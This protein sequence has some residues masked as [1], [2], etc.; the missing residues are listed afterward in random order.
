MTARKPLSKRSKYIVDTDIIK[1]EKKEKRSL[2][3]RPR[4]S[5]LGDREEVRSKKVILL[6]YG[7]VEL[8]I[9]TAKQR[10]YVCSNNGGPAPLTHELPPPPKRRRQVTY[11]EAVE[12]TLQPVRV[13][14]DGVFDIFHPG[15]ARALMQAKNA[16]PNVH[17][18]AGGIHINPFSSQY[19]IY[20]LCSDM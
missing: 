17:L 5:A 1:E 7:F 16:F 13:Y 8:F 3:S 18:I 19:D 14:A 6:N 11:K 9:F 15:H 10:R 4:P 12:G 20:A 2:K